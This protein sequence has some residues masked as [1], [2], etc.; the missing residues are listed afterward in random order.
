MPSCMA[1]WAPAS[2]EGMYSFGMRPPVTVFSKTYPFSSPVRGSRSTTTRAN[3][4]D[5][6]VCFLWVYS[7][8][9]TARRTVSR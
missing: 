9:E 7:T 4:P 3:W 1:S 5:P 2:T 6:P 8:L